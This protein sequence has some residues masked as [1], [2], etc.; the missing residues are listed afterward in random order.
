MIESGIRVFCKSRYK[1]HDPGTLF[2]SQSLGDISY[3]IL[4]YDDGVNEPAEVGLATPGQ[5]L[6]F[7]LGLRYVFNQN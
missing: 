4:E 2:A 5:S 6:G 1:H 3:R 7:Q